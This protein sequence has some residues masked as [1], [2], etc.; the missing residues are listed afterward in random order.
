MTK[1][2]F[3]AR[4]F[5]L[6]SPSAHDVASRGAFLHDIYDR[7]TR[8]VNPRRHSGTAAWSDVRSDDPYIGL[9]LTCLSDIGSF[10]IM[11]SQNKD[12]LKI[13]SLSGIPRKKSPVPPDSPLLRPSTPQSP[14]SRRARDIQREARRAKNFRASLDRSGSR[15][16]DGTPARAGTPS[17][18]AMP[19]VP[20][21]MSFSVKPSVGGRKGWK[22]MPESAVGGDPDPDILQKVIDLIHEMEFSGKSVPERIT[23]KV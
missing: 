20:G 6:T 9:N 13:D 1:N 14:S 16:R 17:K 2:F 10:S 22:I 5:G 7:E 19:L 12:L 11:A 15:S 8:S 23:L 21:E 3:F 18:L 4:T